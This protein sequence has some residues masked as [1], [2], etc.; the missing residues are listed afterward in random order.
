MALDLSNPALELSFLPTPLY[1]IQLKPSAPIPPALLAV[2]AGGPSSP[3]PPPFLSFTRTPHETSIILPSDLCNSIYPPKGVEQPHETSGPWSALVVKGPMDL[4]L[5]GERERESYLC[6]QALTGSLSLSRHLLPSFP[7][8]T[9]RRFL[10]SLTG[11]MHELTRPLKEAEVPV[12]A[13]STWDTDY[14]L[15]NKDKMEVARSALKKAGWR[16]SS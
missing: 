9:S 4:S 11:I 8:P 7:S 14:V 2:L 10:E 6:L 15:I 5:T 12:F 13:S 1:I 16:F 3:N